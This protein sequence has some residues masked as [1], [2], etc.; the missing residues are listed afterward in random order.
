MA[1]KGNVFIKTIGSI[2]RSLWKLFLIGL[3]TCAKVIGFLSTLT[4]KIAEKLLN[5]KS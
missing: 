3:Y 2:L 4:A 1:H 5:L